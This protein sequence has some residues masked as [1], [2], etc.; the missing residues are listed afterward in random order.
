MRRVLLFLAVFG[1]VSVAWAADD[2]FV[3]T[4]N[5]NPA[6]S[7]FSYP[8]PKS[9]TVIFTAQDNGVKVVQDMVEA[10]GKAIHR[11]FALKYDGKDYPVT[12]PD[13]DAISVKK[14]DPNT[15]EYV[16]KKNGKEVWRGR[17]VVFKDGKSITDIG[18]GKDA[19]GQAFTYTYFLEKQ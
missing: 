2:P 1:L 10:D 3:G 8:A 12:A 17:A 6:K 4:W 5:M 13:Q 15:A 19:K 18:S 7:K 16:G 9:F 11:S 14:P